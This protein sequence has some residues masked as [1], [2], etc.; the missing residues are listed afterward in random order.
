[1]DANAAEAASNADANITV[2]SNAAEFQAAM[3]YGAQ[4]IE[5]RAHLDV[6]NLA[7]AYNSDTSLPATVL[8][9]VKPSTRSIRVRIKILSEA[10]TLWHARTA[11]CG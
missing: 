8:G 9:D 1:M 3:V 6:D 2:A 5:L 10:C 4:D 11:S 7:L